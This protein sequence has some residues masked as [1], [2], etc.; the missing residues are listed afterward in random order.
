MDRSSTSVRYNVRFYLFRDLKKYGN[1][2]FGQI[3]LPCQGELVGKVEHDVASPAFPVRKVR[4]RMGKEI[5]RSCDKQ[6]DD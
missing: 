1:H 2:C 4:Q 6:E 3:S 5:W